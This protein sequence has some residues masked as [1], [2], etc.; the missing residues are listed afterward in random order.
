MRLP[1]DGRS[2]CDEA[3]KT[4]VKAHDLREK[5][6]RQSRRHSCRA[7]LAHRAIEILS[8]KFIGSDLLS[9]WPAT[10]RFSPD[11]ARRYEQAICALTE[12]MGMTLLGNPKMGDKMEQLFCPNSSFSQ[13][14]NFTAEGSPSLCLSAFAGDFTSR[15]GGVTDG[16]RKR[17]FNRVGD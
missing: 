15:K 5:I 1:L 16:T 11:C 7:R 2:Y 10:K 3:E 13:F 6:G 4:R 14:G 9:D 12:R 17:K 8:D